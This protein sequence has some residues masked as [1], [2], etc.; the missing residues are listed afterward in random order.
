M[1]ADFRLVP[2]RVVRSAILKRVRE[3]AIHAI[4]AQTPRPIFA[5]L[6]LVQVR[7]QRGVHAGAFGT[8]FY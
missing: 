6:R 2:V 1:L 3:G 8:P 4:A 5:K 7:V